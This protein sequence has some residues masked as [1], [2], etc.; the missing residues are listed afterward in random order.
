MQIRPLDLDNANETHA[1]Y[2]ALQ[3]SYLEGNPERPM[4]TE[5]EMLGF[6][7]EPIGEEAYATA[8]VDEDGAVAGGYIVFYPML[9]NVTLAWTELFVVPDRRG[10]G[11]GS[12]LTEHITDAVSAKGR[13]SLLTDIV[14]PFEERDDHPFRRFAEKR[15]CTLATTEVARRLELPVDD[16][17]IQAWIDEA[18]PRHAGYRIETYTDGNFPDEIVPSLCHTANQLALEAP[19]GEL[20][21][22]AEKLTPELWMQRVERDRKQ[23]MLRYDSVALDE[24]GSVV[25]LTTIAV[26]ANARDRTQALQWATIVLPGHRGHRLGLALKARNLRVLQQNHPERTS[27]HTCNAE[28]NAPMIDI[29]E[30][31]GFKPVELIAGFQ[32]KLS[33]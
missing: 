1:F 28:V 32:R 20:E 19:H 24:T 14:M 10:H 5:S 11:V 30:R 21:I 25:A 18:A 15:G 9:D 26:P 27:V 16:G 29:N 22:E 13:A 33:E 7:R 12:A 8:A 31:I 4:W 17:Q 2:G 6:L 3:V 23:G